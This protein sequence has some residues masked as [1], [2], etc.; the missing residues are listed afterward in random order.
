LMHLLLKCFLFFSVSLASNVCF[1]KLL[2]CQ[3]PVSKRTPN[4][5]IFFFRISSPLLLQI[6]T[7][8]E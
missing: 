5:S 2:A 8:K 7:G 1:C 4:P 3:D 6:R